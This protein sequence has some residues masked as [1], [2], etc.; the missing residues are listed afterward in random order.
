ME[1]SNESQV[2]DKPVLQ[3]YEVENQEIANLFVIMTKNE[4]HISH[5]KGN[6][7]L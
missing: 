4:S 6:I 7:F 5:A 1:G 3:F 2:E